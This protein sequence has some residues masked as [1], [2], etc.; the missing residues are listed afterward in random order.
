MP[1]RK[2]IDE[3]LAQSHIGF[4]GLS[5]NPRDFSH[6]VYRHLRDGGRTLYPVNPNSR[7]LEA[8]RCYGSVRDLPVEVES[9]FVM[10][11]A[12]ASCTVVQDCVYRG[13]ER[14]WFHRGVGQ[15]AVSEEAIELARRHDMSVVDGACPFMFDDPVRHV[16]RVHKWMSGKRIAA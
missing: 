4:V 9:V 12:R 6:A 7:E 13:I 15:G 11:N 16:H 14:V 1:T 8:D 3:F 5:R 10:V 2:A